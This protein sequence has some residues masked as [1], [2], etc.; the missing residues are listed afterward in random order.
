MCLLFALHK[1]IASDI[2]IQYC[3]RPY[4]VE[5]TGSPPT[6]EVK[7]RRARLVLGWGTAWEDLRVLSAFSYSMS[8]FF[9][10]GSLNAC[11][12]VCLPVCRI[13]CFHVCL[14]ASISLFLSQQGIA[15]RFRPASKAPMQFAATGRDEMKG[16]MVDRVL[17]AP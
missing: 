6:S 3:W 12:S 13:I 4:R 11:P 10:S 15:R 9:A 1:L 14:S 5:C 17:E 8:G 2:H 16:V 7:R